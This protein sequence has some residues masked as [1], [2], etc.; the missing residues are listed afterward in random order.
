MC[1]CRSLAVWRGADPPLLQ[2]LPLVGRGLCWGQELDRAQGPGGHS[3]SRG[4]GGPTP[5]AMGH[6]PCSVHTRRYTRGAHLG[7]REQPVP[8]PLQATPRI[9]LDASFCLGQR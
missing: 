9:P 6:T 4:G 1:G 3:H 8:Q 5:H 2:E 7:S